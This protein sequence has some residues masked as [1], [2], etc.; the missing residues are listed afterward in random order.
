[1]EKNYIIYEH[2]SPCGKRYIGVTSQK[3]GNRWKHG[4]GYT[5]NDYFTKAIKKYG[6]D[7]FEHN[8]LFDGLTKEEASIREKELIAKYNTTNRDYGYNI[9]DGGEGVAGYKHSDKVKHQISVSMKGNDN[10]L[11]ESILQ[12]D[13]KG[14]FIKEYPSISDASRETGAP[15]SGISDAS[16]LKDNSRYSS[17][18]FIWLHKKDYSRELL[19]KYVCK[20]VE[21]RIKTN[22]A[23]TDY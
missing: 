11:S 15:R 8:I 3:A 16:N 5:Y 19:K 18:G 14:N 2:V 6:W 12:F 21:H 10:C 23:N 9:A 20:V 17:G 7:N 13:L 4:F 22:R 1:M